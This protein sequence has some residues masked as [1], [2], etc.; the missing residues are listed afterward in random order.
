VTSRGGEQ[1]ACWSTSF[2]GMARQV[3]P[4]TRISQAR[5]SSYMLNRTGIG[6]PDEAAIE[7]E[8]VAVIIIRRRK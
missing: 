3:L 4:S 1:Q 8:A 5:L 7:Q 6:I 2:P